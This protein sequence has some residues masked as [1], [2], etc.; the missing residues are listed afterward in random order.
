MGPPVIG[1]TGLTE[2]SPV[3]PGASVVSVRESYVRAVEAGGGAPLVV[4]PLPDDARLRSVFDRLDGLVLSGGGDIS[5]SYYGEQN[6]GL[7]W[8]VD[9]QRDRA[10]LTLARWA[11]SGGLPLLAICRG[12]QAL[13]VAAGGS[14]IQDVGTQI[15][16][17]LDHTILAGRPMAAIA[18]TVDVA[19]RT[20]LAG[21]FGPGALEVNSAHHQAA[22][23]VGAGL[24]VTA[25]APDGVIEGLEKPDHPFCVGVQWHPE[26]MIDTRP[27]MIRLFEALAGAARPT[28]V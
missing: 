19:E 14:L 1:I 8:H 24:V 2:Q 13:N 21:L 4:V 5:P 18:H 11:L 10:E 28:R 12:I 26:A 9:E 17:A 6:S 23:S 15:P 7:L 20:R 25:R 27:A 16:N 3:R 22:D